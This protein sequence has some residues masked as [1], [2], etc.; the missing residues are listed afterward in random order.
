M[1]ER[2]DP[3]LVL[4]ILGATGGKPLTDR[5]PCGCEM[6]QVGEAFVYRPCSLD[7]RYYRYAMAEAERQDKPMG[8]GFEGDLS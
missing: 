4:Q 6:G 5:L 3:A 7:C 1:S 2:V 8:F